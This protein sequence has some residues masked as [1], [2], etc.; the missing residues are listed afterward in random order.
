ME[1]KKWKKPQE[2]PHRRD[3][4]PQSSR[5]TGIHLSLTTIQTALGSGGPQT[6]DDLNEYY[7]E[8]LLCWY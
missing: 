1:E 4:C 5:F 3:P 8:C 7:A 2:E 6:N